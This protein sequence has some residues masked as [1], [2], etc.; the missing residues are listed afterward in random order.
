MT[1][2]PNQHTDPESAP[3]T[4]DFVS[5]APGRECGTCTL[6]CKVYPIPAL[7]K[8]AGVWCRH[9]TPGKGC[10]IHDAPPDQ[11]RAFFCL[12]MM[13]GKM[14]PEWR[15]DR[16]KFV[17]SRS[18][19]NRYIYGQVDPGAPGSWRRAPY[20]DRLRAAAKDLLAKRSFIVMLEGD[21]ATL[22]TPEGELP[23]GKI[24]GIDSFRIE[25]K[26]GPKGLTW[27]ATRATAHENAQHETDEADTRGPRT[28]ASLFGVPAPASKSGQ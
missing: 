4:W 14:P 1:D 23:L 12:W 17:L 27:R 24:D 5:A 25:A 26:F 13:D 19:R 18:R 28:E 16:A 20:Y 9:C 11:C 3:T 6:C 15:P 22:I 10:G 2:Q 7:E 8:P 21:Q